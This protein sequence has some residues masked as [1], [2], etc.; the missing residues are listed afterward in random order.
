MDGSGRVIQRL[1]VR[2]ARL[3]LTSG[4]VKGGMIPKLEA[5]LQA[6]GAGSRRGGDRW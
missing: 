3:L 6:L 2:N 5:C 4:V 1:N